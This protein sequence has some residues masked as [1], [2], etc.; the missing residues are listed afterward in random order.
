MT[1]PV[2]KGSNI[3]LFDQIDQKNYFECNTCKAIFLDRK[4]H[5]TL[6]DEQERYIQHN[7]DIYDPEYRRFLSRLY[8]P[9]VKKLSAGVM[10]LDYG[11]GPGPALVQMFREA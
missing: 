10:G 6:Q 4:S 9:I 8:N 11:C 2:C 3:E 7:N 1:C 5:L